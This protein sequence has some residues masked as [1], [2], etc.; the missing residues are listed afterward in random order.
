[1]TDNIISINPQNKSF[2][3]NTEEVDINSIGWMD[4]NDNIC[5]Q[6]GQDHSHKLKAGNT[7]LD[8]I[9]LFLDKEI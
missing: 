6:C 7:S 5:P 3:K 2:V 4:Y 9:S 1:M 8:M